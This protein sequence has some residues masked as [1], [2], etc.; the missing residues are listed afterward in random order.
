MCSRG[1]SEVSEKGLLRS[2]AFTL[3]E[4]LVV[5][6]IIALLVSILLPALSK[7]RDSAKCVMC[8]CN[9]RQLGYGIE[10]Y[11]EDH[12]GV[13]PPGW[14]VAVGTTLA[15]NWMP[16]IS[17][18]LGERKPEIGT[19]DDFWDHRAD[20]KVWNCPNFASEH[21]ED[22][23]WRP[24][25]KFNYAMNVHLSFNFT[26]P[27][28]AP[29]MS[30]WSPGMDFTGLKRDS[31]RSPSEKILI[32]DGSGWQVAYDAEMIY[33]VTVPRAL[34]HNRPSGDL[35]GPGGRANVLLAGLSVSQDTLD[36]S[37]AYAQFEQYPNLYPW[38][39]WEAVCPISW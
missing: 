12:D 35:L 34:R 33:L 25:Y 17:T 5:V 4:L 2:R 13:M 15:N 36:R 6:S 26:P 10:Y 23:S 9:L 27:T 1:Y 7:A 29:A 3:I 14:D 32:S 38:G 28:S 39:A 20:E 30:T 21:P 8:Q 24:W 19:D 22:P 16:L 11:A 37:K 31:I 18:Y